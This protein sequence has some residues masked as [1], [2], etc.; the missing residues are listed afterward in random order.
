MNTKVYLIRHAQSVKNIKDIHGGIGE[1]LTD[2]GIMQANNLADKLLAQGI[3]YANSVLF[4]PQNLQVV[5]T[6]SIL[7][8]KIGLQ[9]I[10]I[11][12]F[13]PVY[14]GVISG[15]SNIEV[16]EKY[17]ECFQLLCRWRNKEIE[18]CDVDIPGMEKPVDFFIRGQAILENI[19]YNKNNI[20]ICTSSLYVLLLNILLGNTPVHGG[21]YKH[22][23]IQNCGLTLFEQ[24]RCKNCFRLNRYI[25][26][27]DDVCD[28]PHE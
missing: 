20:F 5:E 26:D 27:V 15:L 1:R 17:P 6:A 28:Y 16:E 7:K 19:Q 4:Y 21:G 13:K 11:E 25:T 12:E 24:D 8:E 10:E 2:C 23:N 22:F 14:L 9:Q 18:I 3:N